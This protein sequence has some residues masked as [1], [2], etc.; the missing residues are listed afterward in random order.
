M[1][2]Y[3][4]L[5]YNVL[6]VF[7]LFIIVNCVILGG[8]LFMVECGYNFGEFVIYGF[9]FGFGWVLVIIVMVGVCEKLKYFDILD[10]L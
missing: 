9:F 5:F 10:G 8:F 2:K 7:L 1:D 6:G 4:L 3:F